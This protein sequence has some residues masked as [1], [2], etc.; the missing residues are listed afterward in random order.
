MHDNVDSRQSHNNMD[1][2]PNS[3]DRGGISGNG[4]RCRNGGVNVGELFTLVMP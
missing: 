4:M 2:E 3:D 1:F